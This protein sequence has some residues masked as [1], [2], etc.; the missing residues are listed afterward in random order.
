LAKEVW[1]RFRGEPEGFRRFVEETRGLVDYYLVEDERLASEAKSLDVKTVSERL[2]DLKLVSRLEDVSPN[3]CLK[4]E[5]KSGGDEEKAV[6]ASDMGCRY[7]L[8]RCSDW[9]IIPLENLVAKLHGRTK[10]IAEASGIEDAETLLKVLELGVDGVLIETDDPKEVRKLRESVDRVVLKTNVLEL[11][12]AKV[13]SIR[14]LKLGARVCL[15]T[16]D[17]LS[18]CEGFLV[19]CQSAGLFLIEAEVH[20]NPYVEARP[21]RVN[22]GPPAL[23]IL[24]PSG[25][26]RY[27]SELRAGET[28]LAV[29]GDGTFREV[30]LCRVKIEWRPLKLVEAEYEGKV[31]KVV[32][33][34]AET[35]RFVT[36]EGS[37]S[38]AELSPGDE[39]L[40]F[41]QEEGGRHFGTLVK[42]ERIIER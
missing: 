31:Y 19:G 5:V 6:K 23:Y 10:I 2:G 17:M 4:I 27:L 8:V 29:K 11:R 16:C 26:T 13:I 28:L 33:Q 7:V 39:I 15:D 21:F 40:I 22:A 3:S 18:P 34:D 41:V 42:G 36:P 37:I 20:G 38:L 24:A 35:I 30:E 1:I 25:K 14:P 9:K 32:V 12:R